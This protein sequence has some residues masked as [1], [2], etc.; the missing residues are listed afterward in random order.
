MQFD[1]STNLFA[2]DPNSNKEVLQ[3]KIEAL[4]GMEYTDFLKCI[5][6]NQP[7]KMDELYG[8]ILHNCVQVKRRSIVAFTLDLS[9]FA[10]VYAGT[11][12]SSPKP[13]NFMFLADTATRQP[14]YAFQVKGKLETVSDFLAQARQATQFVMR[15]SKI[16]TP[17]D[18]K[19]ATPVL[20]LRHDLAHNND[21]SLLEAAGYDFVVDYYRQLPQ[22]H[23][24]GLSNQAQVD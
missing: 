20:I 6:Q 12:T 2:Q 19:N 23:D 4:L 9:N 13:L 7:R 11:V 24:R 10:S 18:Q 16:R 8:K 14:F 5:T 17:Q 15:H 21:L 22:S 1:V 3:A